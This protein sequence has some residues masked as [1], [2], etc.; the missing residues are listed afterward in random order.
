VTTF[1][2]FTPTG[3]LLSTLTGAGL[4]AVFGGVSGAV[5]GSPGETI[6]I[7]KEKALV[8]VKR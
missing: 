7:S 6:Y 3:H 5:A 1:D 8:E 4:G 2:D